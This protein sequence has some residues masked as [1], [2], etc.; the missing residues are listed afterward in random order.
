M[1]NFS[2]DLRTWTIYLF[3]NEEIIPNRQNAEVLKF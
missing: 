1:F 2:E 3:P